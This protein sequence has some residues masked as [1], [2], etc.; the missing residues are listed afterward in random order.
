MKRLTLQHCIDIATEREG[1]CLSTEYKNKDH[2]MLWQC[3]IGHEWSTSFGNIK[4]RNSWCSKCYHISQ[5]YTLNDCIKAAILNDD[6]CLSKIY[7]SSEEKMKWQCKKNHIWEASFDSIINCFSWCPYCSGLYNNNIELCH[8]IAKNRGGECLSVEYKNTITKMKWRCKRGHEWEAVFDSI[9]NQNC[10]CP[11]CP[12]NTS[13]AEKELFSYLCD[14]FTQLYIINNDRVAIKPMEL[15]IYIPELKLA[16]E[17]DGE[18]WHYSDWA[19]K[20]GARKRMSRKNAKCKE[21]DITL[22]RIREKDWNINKELEL[23]AIVDV[24]EHIHTNTYKLVE[25]V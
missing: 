22:I 6:V 2:V 9:K 5:K 19:V 11:Y 13:R 25:A 20:E 24:I 15:D 17:Y 3:R 21:N 16:I 1:K 8:K 23:Q 18:H 14:I 7:V 10:W 12:K 4:N